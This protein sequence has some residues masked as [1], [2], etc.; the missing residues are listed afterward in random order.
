MNN[1]CINCDHDHIVGNV[2]AIDRLLFVTVCYTLF[3]NLKNANNALLQVSNYQQY[4]QLCGH[5]HMVLNVRTPM[6]KDDK[7]DR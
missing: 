4:L 1:N 3:D 7:H 2:S 5:D 6:N